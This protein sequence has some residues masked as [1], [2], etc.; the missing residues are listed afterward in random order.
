MSV[1][2]DIPSPFP[3][4]VSL[5]RRPVSYRLACDRAE[6]VATL[7]LSLM[8]GLAIPAALLWAADPFAHWPG[9]ALPLTRI[10]A[11]AGLIRFLVFGV[12]AWLWPNIRTVL[13]RVDVTITD[14]SIEVAAKSPFGTCRWSKPL[15]EYAGVAIE[16]WGT[17]TVG[18]DKIPLAAIMLVHRDD[19]FSVP[20]RIDGA[21]RVK[22]SLARGKADQLGLPLIDA[23]RFGLR[24]KE[25]GAIVVNHAQ[26]VKV[27]MLHALLGLAG[28]ATAAV[29]FAQFAATA[30]ITA[31]AVGV[32]GIA[33]AGAI[34]I[35][36]SCYVTALHRKDSA[37]EIDTA[38]PLTGKQP[39]APSRH[40]YSTGPCFTFRPCHGSPGAIA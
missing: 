12:R 7:L 29:A 13:T 24:A 8:W 16:N 6:R 22:E 40:T 26:A 21:L 11:F 33:L 27:R 32:L 9:D 37:I 5:K 10:A 31:L 35:F 15:G 4:T 30:E 23:P 2:S 3:L 18:N 38:A 14:G 34:H 39:P 25:L 28:I 19:R 17:R 36:A 20:I 1:F